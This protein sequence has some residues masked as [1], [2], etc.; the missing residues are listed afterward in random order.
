MKQIYNFI[1]LLLLVLG[2]CSNPRYGNILSDIDSLSND[3]PKQA[4]EKLDSLYSVMDTTNV[5]DLMY[6]KLVKLKA[7]G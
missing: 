7:T 4:L 1:L 5:S 2:S 3:N 6:Y